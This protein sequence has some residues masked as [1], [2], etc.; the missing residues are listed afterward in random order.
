[1]FLNDLVQGEIKNKEGAEMQTL[2]LRAFSVYGIRTK[3]IF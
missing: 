2:H 3:P 1:M